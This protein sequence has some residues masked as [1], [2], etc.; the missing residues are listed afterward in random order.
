MREEWIYNDGGRA[1]FGS[2]AFA[3]D[4]ACR[5]IAIATGHPYGDVYRELTGRNGSTPRDGTIDTASDGYLRGHGWTRHRLESPVR[6]PLDQL[7]AGRLVVELDGHLTA[8]IDR[9]IHDTYDPRQRGELVVTGYYLHLADTRTAGPVARRDDGEPAPTSRG[10]EVT[11]RIKSR[12]RQLLKVAENRGATEAEVRNALRF[13]QNLMRR[14]NIERDDLDEDDDA[15]RVRFA[16]AAVFMNGTRR[17]RWEIDLAMFITGSLCPS[18]DCYTGRRQRPGRSES[19]SCVWFY[20]PE[21]DVT[22]SVDLFEEMIVSIAASAR[23]RG[24]GGFARG[25]GAKYCEGFVAGL[26]EAFAQNESELRGTAEG[27]E[28]IAVSRRRSLALS[29]AA[30]KWLRE[31]EGIRLARGSGLQGGRGS[32]DAYRSGVQDGRRTSVERN[33]AKLGFRG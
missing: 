29:A 2:I 16:R 4:C 9:V 3:G 24:F 12:I 21:T 8:V 6:V 32:Y 26:R 23:L 10:E 19:A 13:A 18:C 28:M 11:C 33:Q 22:F 31:S 17:T 30:N 25:D 14:H 1:L 27:R 15:S 5:A 7:P 20:G